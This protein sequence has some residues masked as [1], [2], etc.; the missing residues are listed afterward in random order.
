MSTI[1]VKPER[2]IATETRA[3]PPPIAAGTRVQPPPSI[4][5]ETRAQPPPIAAG[6]DVRPGDRIVSSTSA[7]VSPPQPPPA[8]KVTTRDAAPVPA[9][10]A[11]GGASLVS[12]MVHTRSGEILHAT[13][14][15]IAKV[16]PAQK[17]VRPEPAVPYRLPVYLVDRVAVY[18]AIYG[19]YDQLRPHPPIEGVDFHV[20]TDDDRLLDR[21]DWEVHVAPSR[22]P[23]RV[24]A[25][26]HKVLGPLSPSLDR[27]AYT[28]WIDGSREITSARFVEEAL[29]DL[30]PDGIALHR[31]TTECIYEESAGVS[32]R[33][34]ELPRVREQVASYRDEG[35]PARS[36]V[37]AG[38]AIARTRG[39]KIEAAMRA[40]WE[41][42]EKWTLRDQLSLPVIL[43]RHALW[44]TI[45]AGTWHGSP[46][47]KIHAH[48]DGT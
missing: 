37:F 34:H 18:T 22:E 30:G 40:W 25:K 7:R 48:R 13:T 19:G 35:H 29:A 17:A 24:A 39:S 43:R 2:T 44:P 9:P 6:V 3:Q 28:I 10:S 16:G 27:Y 12:T 14:S 5:T 15:A 42:I 1:D 46:W 8:T 26:R 36:G 4:V 38:G 11:A 45:W 20:F 23:P 31:A 33:K 32:G 21:D 41:E 47:W